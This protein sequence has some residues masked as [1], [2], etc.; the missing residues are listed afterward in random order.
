MV[1]ARAV[2]LVCV[3]AWELRSDVFLYCPTRRQKRQ[4]SVAHLWGSL[5]VLQ[6]L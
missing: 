3:L 1:S 2:R 5:Q 4:H 6:E